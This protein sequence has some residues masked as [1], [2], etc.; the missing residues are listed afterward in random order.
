MKLRFQQRF[1]LS[2]SVTSAL[3]N[4]GMFRPV[5]SSEPESGQEAARP[6]G[7]E[8]TAPAQ[9]SPP[10]IGSAP[11]DFHRIAYT[12][13]GD[14]HNEHIVCVHGFARNGRDFDFLAER[15]STRACV[16]CPDVVG[17]GRSD[18]LRDP[19]TNFGY[20]YAQ[21]MLDIT[22]LIGCFGVHEVDWVGTSL[23]GLLGMMMAAAPRSPVRR[24]VMND[25]GPQL[26]ASLTP[27]LL[28]Y[29]ADEHIFSSPEELRE[30][31]REHYCGTTKFGNLTEVQLRHMAKYSERRLPDGRM[32]LAFDHE[33]MSYSKW[34]RDNNIPF[35]DVTLWDV[36]A[37][38][39]C[40]VLVLHG[41]NSPVLLEETVMRMHQEGPRANVVTI[42]DCGHAPSLMSDAQITLID[43]WLKTTEI[44]QNVVAALGAAARTDRQ[45]A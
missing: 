35:E 10:P 25:V 7:S 3:Q 6:G 42:P 33:N 4:A 22:S 2:L 19:T 28:D 26:P 30:F 20:S 24:L 14:P 29:L 43:T 12:Q 13:W 34:M 11:A 9:P 17:R 8:A 44:D 38:V 27:S 23:G 31:L 45:Y 40:P 41:A 21:Y 32:G 18:W 16:V 5:Q 37:N 15:L 39:R 36:W 1:L